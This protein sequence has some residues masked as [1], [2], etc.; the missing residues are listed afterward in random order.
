MCLLLLPG[1]V[2]SF[3]SQAANAAKIAEVCYNDENQL[4]ELFMRLAEA[5]NDVP[6]F[7]PEPLGP[8]EEGSDSEEDE[9]SGRPGTAARPPT[10]N[11][12]QRPLTEKQLREK[13]L[14]AQADK[15][16]DDKVCVSMEILCHVSV[17]C[18]Q[19]A[20]QRNDH[21]LPNALS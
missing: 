5:Y 17:V 3:T 20:D 1:W 2:G 7:E 11:S 10:G 21:C 18:V 8:A 15:E 16:L 4:A 6:L 12:K 14:E 19:H 9:E 13:Q